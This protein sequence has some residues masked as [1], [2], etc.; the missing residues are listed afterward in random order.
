MMSNGVSETVISNRSGLIASSVKRVIEFLTKAQLINVIDGCVFYNGSIEQKKK[1]KSIAV[2]E[3]KYSEIVDLL[4]AAINATSP[5]GAVT[6]HPTPND[7]AVIAIMIDKDQIDQRA[8]IAI[9]TMYT[10]IPFWGE[11]YIVQSAS[12]LR[13]HW[14]RIYSAAGQHYATKRVEKI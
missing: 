14:N 8:L 5:P 4:Y 9:L 11:K 10:T 7:Y 12:G 2:I 3:K 13:K 1:E 6:K